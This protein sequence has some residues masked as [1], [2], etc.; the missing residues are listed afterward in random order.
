VAGHGVSARGKRVYKEAVKS[1]ISSNRSIMLLLGLGG[2]AIAMAACGGGNNTTTGA[3]GGGGSGNHASSTH[4]AVQGSSSSGGPVMCAKT[5]EITA[6]AFRHLGNDG[7]SSTYGGPSLP[8]TGDATDVD[9]VT[10][11]FYGSGVDPSNDGEKT[12]S[13][14]LTAT[15]DTDYATCSRCVLVHLDPKKMGKVYFQKSGTLVVDPTSDQL[16]GTIKATLTDVTLIEVTI[17]DM[18]FESTTVAN[19]SCLHLAT[20]DITYAKKPAPATWTCDG[21]FYDDAGCDCGCGVIDFDCKDAT[22]A[23]CEFCDN[24]G[25]CSM[26]KCPGT[27][28][29]TD[30]SICM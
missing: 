18:T 6:G 24:M 19:P 13:F 7:D 20:A 27:I 2:V 5:T 21:S 17:D 15:A 12:G 10:I 29:T 8:D 26:D 22:L 3:N 11:E 14:D 25:S 4:G 28:K 16:N 9:A 23:S 30:N 1:K